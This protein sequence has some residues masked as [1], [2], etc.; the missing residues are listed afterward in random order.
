VDGVRTGKSDHQF[1]DKIPCGSGKGNKFIAHAKENEND[2]D[3]KD[4]GGE[5]KEIGEKENDAA[6]HAFVA[7]IIEKK[8]ADIQ[9]KFCH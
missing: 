1:D 9:K 6:P 4:N 3:G 2:L 5:Q 7:F 8:P